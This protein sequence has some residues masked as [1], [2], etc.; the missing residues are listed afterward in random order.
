MSADTNNSNTQTTAATPEVRSRFRYWQTRT[1]LLTMIGYALYYFVRKNFSMAMPGMEADL[2][3][4]KTNLGVYL[5]ANGII[6]GISRFVNGFFADRCNARI[7]M[8]TGLALCAVSNFAFGFGVDI[9][10]WISGQSS[11]SGF[12]NVLILF[13][14][15]TWLINGALQGT[16]FPPCARLLTHWIP[17]RELATKMSV[18]NTSHSIGAGLVVIL[19]G[20]IMNNMGVGAHHFGAWRWCFW[21]PAGIAMLGS[22]MLFVFLRD[23]PKSV[24]L[25][26]LEG[27]TVKLRKQTAKSAEYSAFLREKV[28]G[29]PLIWILGFANF[30]VY[31]VRFSVLDWG[32]TLLKQSKGVSLAHAGWMVALFEIAGIVGMLV[33]GWATDRY[34]KGRAHRTCVFCMI[35]STICAVLLWQIPVGGSSWMLFAVLCATGFFIYGPQALVGIAA[36]NQATKKAAA[37]ANGLTGMFAYAS[38]A[39]SGVGFGY[40]AQHYGWN[41]AYF[42]IIG[43]SLV[44]AGIFMLMWNAKADGYEEKTNAN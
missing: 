32:P 18:W 29:N 26:E 25:P 9:A 41:I 15:L 17:P 40:V 38:T 7:Y 30:F 24:G 2:G 35:G 12:T 10:S 19:C 14:G 28:F 27:T 8:A 6:Y 22:I 37:T 39:V 21:I 31:I 42:A 43:M 34:L 3:I 16:G 36:A 1:I 44:G 13:L 23:T 20:Y 4:S 11:G 33:A 5:T